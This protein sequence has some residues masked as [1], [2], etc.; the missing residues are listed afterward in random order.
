MDIDYNLIRKLM[1]DLEINGR[2]FIIRDRRITRL[3]EQ[4]L[5]PSG[6][7]DDLIYF[8][9]KSSLINS[10][11]E[12]I[13]NYLQFKDESDTSRVAFQILVEKAY[14]RYIDFEPHDEW[15]ERVN[16]K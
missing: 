2:Q 3:K 9:I 13:F 7:V 8:H 16:S 15:M 12:Q 4:G 14:Q 10:V 11:M 6:H 1:Y 5:Y